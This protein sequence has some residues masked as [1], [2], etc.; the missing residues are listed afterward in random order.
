ME[1]PITKPSIT[2]LEI[3]NILDASKNGWGK[4]CHGYINKFERELSSYL[5]VKYVILTSSCF[6]AI[7]LALKALKIERGD[8]IIL[9][10]IN[11]IATVAPIVHLN[12]KPIFVDIDPVSWCI[13][14]KEIERKISS[15]TKAII[16]THLYGNICDIKHIIR[17]SKKYKIPVIEDAAEAFGSS[18]KNKKVGTFADFGCYSF[19]GT[20]TITTGEGGALVTNSKKLYKI[21]LKLS[22]HG[23]NPKR[24]FWSDLIGFKFKMSNL[25]AALGYAQIKRIHQLIKKKITIF[26]LYKKYLVKKNIYLNPNRKGEI[27]S[28]WMPTVVLKKSVKVNREKIF[29]KLKQNKIDSRVFFYPLSILPMFKNKKTNKISYE[30]YKRGFNLPSYFDL[31]ENKIKMISKIVNKYIR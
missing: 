5:N 27:N 16:A 23:K 29:K 11:W 13:N 25:Q 18:I 30:I 12:A 15:K 4:N 17:I 28:Y 10:D 14:P 7:Y 1:I 20:K 2:S 8:E 26:K 24:Q 22:D 3:K 21:A 6:G 9:A 19:H 31:S